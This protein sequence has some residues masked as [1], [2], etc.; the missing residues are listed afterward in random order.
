MSMQVERGVQPIK[1]RV[2][3]TPSHDFSVVALVVR[4]IPLTISFLLF[5][6]AVSV[7]ANRWGNRLIQILIASA[8]FSGFIG[9]VL[10]IPKRL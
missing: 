9:L 6:L 4:A 8:I 7:D 2:D 5:I 3:N 1:P 10:F